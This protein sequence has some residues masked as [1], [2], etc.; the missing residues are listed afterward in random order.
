MKGKT[1]SQRGRSRRSVLLDVPYCHNHPIKN[2]S[3]VFVTVTNQGYTSL[4]TPRRVLF[5][6]RPTPSAL[7]V[8][9]LTQLKLYH[10]PTLFDESPIR[11]PLRVEV[12]HGR[13]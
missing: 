5:S 10:L 13:D 7:P 4:L 1:P 8:F 6:L 2:F 11:T 12:L 3:F 9:L